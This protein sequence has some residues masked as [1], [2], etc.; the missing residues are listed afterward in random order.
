MTCCSFHLVSHVRLLLH[1]GPCFHHV[2]MLPLSLLLRYPQVSCIILPTGWCRYSRASTASV[3]VPAC[4]QTL[5]SSSWFLSSVISL[6]QIYSLHRAN[7]FFSASTLANLLLY[8]PSP[9]GKRCWTASLNCSF[10]RPY[11][12]YVVISQWF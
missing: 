7:H 9:G 12:T 5:F 11:L 3:L 6:C 2:A 4:L 10:P 8:D 1:Q